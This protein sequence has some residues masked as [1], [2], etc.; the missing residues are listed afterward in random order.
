MVFRNLMRARSSWLT[1]APRSMLHQKV[2][3]TWIKTSKNIRSLSV[4]MT[5]ILMMLMVVAS[6][7]SLAIKSLP[8]MSA[9]KTRTLRILNKKTL[10]RWISQNC[11]KLSVLTALGLAKIFR[12]SITFLHLVTSSM[13]WALSLAMISLAQSWLGH[14]VAFSVIR[15]RLTK[16]QIKPCSMICRRRTKSLPKPPQVT[17][18]VI[19]RFLASKATSSIMSP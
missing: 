10:Y 6:S 8:S 5:W 9:R 17:Y 19:F 4:K 2:R 15:A 14:I 1:R 7:K 18:M 11:R 16:R 3:L 12:S 13:R